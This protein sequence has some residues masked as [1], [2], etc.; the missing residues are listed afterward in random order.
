MKTYTQKE[1]TVL[2]VMFLQK[3]PV[4][5]LGNCLGCHPFYGGKALLEGLGLDPKM[6]EDKLG[7][8]I[9]EH[10]LQSHDCIFG[11]EFVTR[12][13]ELLPD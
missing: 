11:A 9:T 4:D 3:V 12:V 2:S 7:L 5:L 8:E 1:R 10:G 13:A 6:V